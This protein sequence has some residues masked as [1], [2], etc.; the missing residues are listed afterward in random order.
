[1]TEFGFENFKDIE[2]P[3]L[4]LEKIVEELSKED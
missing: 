1:M 4:A 3:T 2:V